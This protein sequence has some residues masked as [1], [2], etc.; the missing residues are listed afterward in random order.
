MEKWG[1]RDGY[2]RGYSQ[3]FRWWQRRWYV[4]CRS[5]EFGWELW[6]IDKYLFEDLVK[7]A[8]TSLKTFNNGSKL[9]NTRKTSKTYEKTTGRNT[10]K[11]QLKSSSFIEI[12][13]NQK[14][15]KSATKEGNK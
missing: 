6:V 13:K 8:A 15:V 11:K 2:Q 3:L 7:V 4:P 12:A 9:K 5:F 14:P 10:I 1:T